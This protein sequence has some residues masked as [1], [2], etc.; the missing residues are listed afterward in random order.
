MPFEDGQEVEISISL[1]DGND[2]S[3][4]LKDSLKGSVLKYDNPFD[5]VVTSEDWE[6][7]K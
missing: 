5:P 4:M 6:L 3:E 7:L 1:K 2:N